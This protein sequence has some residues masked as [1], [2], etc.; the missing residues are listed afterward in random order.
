[1]S[2][3][4]L[5][6]LLAALVA[7]I[8]TCSSPATLVN[9]TIFGDDDR[10]ELHQAPPSWQQ[11]ARSTCIV[12]G[13]TGVRGS[14]IRDNGDGRTLTVELNYQHV[15]WGA[16]FVCPAQ[17]FM[18]QVVMR[19]AFCSA[20]LIGPNLV[21]TAGHCVDIDI[22]VCSNLV[23]I[24]DFS[25]TSESD[26]GDVTSYLQS[27][28]YYCKRI[29]SRENSH[30]KDNAFAFGRDYALVELDRPVTGRQP[31]VVAR[32]L[33]SPSSLPVGTSVVNIGYP[34]TLPVKLARGV[35][36]KLVS[37]LAGTDAIDEVFINTDSLAGNSG[38]GTY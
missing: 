9:A 18:N 3:H 17:R 2:L 27:D 14:T 10:L 29:L 26:G 11:T 4:L 33:T 35:V 28:V 6:L 13:R 38:S 34:T 21:V 32:A 24:F 22:G 5:L 8:L 15:R 12:A 19:P 1:M 25:I 16:E 23:F 30:N 31:A 7:L 37:S 20:T 36:K